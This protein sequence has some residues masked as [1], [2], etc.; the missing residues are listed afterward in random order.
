MKIFNVKGEMFDAG[1]DYSTQGIEFNS[2]PAFELADAKPTREVLERPDYELQAS[3]DKAPNR[4]LESM[5]WYSQTAYRFGDY[6]MKYRLPGDADDILHRWLQYFHYNYDA[7]FLFQAQL[8][9]NLGE[10]PVEYAGLAWDEKKYPW[11]PV[12][13]LIIP[14]QEKD[15]TRLDPRHGLLTLQPLGS[16][17][18]LRRVLY[19]ASSALRRKM[20]ARQE[21]SVRSIDEIPG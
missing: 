11:Q 5:R 15:H 10:Q 21:I 12:A 7:E 3:R 13:E 8:V 2:T 9:E 17:N 4:H 19:P 1:R 20:N 18:R 14:K 16:S 6:I